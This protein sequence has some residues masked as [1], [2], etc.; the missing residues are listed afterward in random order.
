VQRDYCVGERNSV[1]SPLDPREVEFNRLST[2]RSRCI[3]VAVFLD[4]NTLLHYRSIDEV[5]WCEIVADR[6][7][8]VVVAASTVA[9]LDRQKFAH[10]L[11]KLRKRAAS[12]V[13]RLQR[14]SE[15]ATPIK[16]RDGATLNFEVLADASS[17]DASVSG[18]PD[19]QLIESAL[20]C[21]REDPGASIAIVTADL[22]LRLKAK[23]R[24]IRVITLPD[25]LKRPD[26]LDASEAR[27]RELERR[28]ADLSR[29]LPLPR[30][31]FADGADFARFEMRR[32]E[33]LGEL[34]IEVKIEV[35]SKNYSPWT[36]A[37]TAGRAGMSHLESA[38]LSMA[39]GG[40]DPSEGERYNRDR[41]AAIKAMR[42]FYRELA[43]FEDLN[44]RTLRLDLSLLND[45]TAPADDIDVSLF[46][47]DGFELF[48]EDDRP[49]PPAE[50][51]PPVRP[52][53][54]FEMIMPF[55]SLGL[56]KLEL[57][58]YGGHSLMPQNVSA[59]TIRRSNSYV[60]EAHIRRVKHGQSASLDPLWVVVDSFESA[61][62][63]AVRYEI[64]AANVPST[65]NGLLNV[66][67]QRS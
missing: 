37:N 16:L 42:E 34:G 46:L 11:S 44:E 63:F 9:E 36:E 45:G 6:E 12:V 4:T 35:F 51:E 23:Q 31:G 32:G 10:N 19:D 14:F 28:V 2:D 22:G 48:D 1:W 30:L 33:R 41:L 18:T 50:P 60:V 61:K 24:D 40:I 47:P 38:V 49:Q 53:N 66:V 21:L 54:R 52:R 25:E 7:V 27:I 20:R 55:A 5:D 39:G 59:N 17:R 13:A 62:S 29:N 64:Q 58:L 15:Q 57:P 26:E 65:V 3:V 67:I 56:P 8:S 43:I